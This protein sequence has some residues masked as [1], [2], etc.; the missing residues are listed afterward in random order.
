[1]RHLASLFVVVAVV[2]LSPLA[3]VRAQEATPGR[4]TPPT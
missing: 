1:M 4:F 2:L 3:V